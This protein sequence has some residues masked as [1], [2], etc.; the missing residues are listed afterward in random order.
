M[1]TSKCDMCFMID[2]CDMIQHECLVHLERNLEYLMSL[3][4]FYVNCIHRINPH[5]NFIYWETIQM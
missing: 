3:E 4:L 5:Q 2:K 1:G